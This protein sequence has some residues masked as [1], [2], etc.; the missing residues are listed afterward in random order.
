MSN[1]ERKDGGWGEL[2]EAGR[3]WGERRGG[4]GIYGSTVSI[5]ANPVLE[6]VCYIAT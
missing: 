2:G 6:R 3:S 1:S 4:V 5:E